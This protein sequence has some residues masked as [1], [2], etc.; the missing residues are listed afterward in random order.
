[1]AIRDMLSS[2]PY[3]VLT[4]GQ[5]VSIISFHKVITSKSDDDILRKVITYYDENNIQSM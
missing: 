3:V 5:Q 1:M 2:D 4:L